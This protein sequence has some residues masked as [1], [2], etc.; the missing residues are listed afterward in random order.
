VL[1]L[2]DLLVALRAPEPRP[3]AASLVQTPLL[4]P[5]TKQ[6]GD[7]LKELQARHLQMAVVINEWGGTEGLV[8]VEDLIE[9]IVGEIADEHDEGSPENRLLEDGS[10]VLDGRA[11]LGTLDEHFGFRPGTEV[12]ETVGGLVSG[13]LGR[14]PE[15]GEELEHAGLRFSIEK[16]DER[17]IL[18]VRVRRA[19]PAETAP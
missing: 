7:L 15:A 18:S 16:A 3:A 5:E 6:L 1:H 8:T 19:E 11:A 2:R 13:L 9:E 10:L 14:V 17:R 4:V 12:Y